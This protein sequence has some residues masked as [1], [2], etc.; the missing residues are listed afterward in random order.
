MALLLVVWGG[1][2]N[3]ERGLVKPKHPC[4]GGEVRGRSYL[5]TRDSLEILG[6]GEGG[7]GGL[8]AP[9]QRRQE[10]ST[11]LRARRA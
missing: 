9:L 4:E 1:H 6:D 8:L 3:E 10:P 11:F 5:G 2:S 7:G